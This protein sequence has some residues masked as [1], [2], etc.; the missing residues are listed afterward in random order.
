MGV[1]ENLQGPGKTMAWI[2]AHLDYPH[3]DFCLIWPFA[4]SRNGYAYVS[5]GIAVHRVMCEHR[6][7]P[8]PDDKSQAAHSCGRGHEGCVNPWHLDWKSNAEN[9]IDRYQQNAPAPRN[10]LTP[11]QVDEI[12][13]LEHRERICDTALRFGVSERNI[14]DI[15]SGRIW[16]KDRIDRHQF[17]E[18]EVEF[19][20]SP[21]LRDKTARYFA[22]QFGVS[23]CA[24]QNI[25]SGRSYRHITVHLPQS[26]AQP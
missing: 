10:K 23:I 1:L 14:R 12:R 26:D 7:G 17:T 3:P 24:I 9:Q 16:K 8:A 13:S 19:I 6:N 18:A 11:Q 20:R 2:R 21:S 4:L 22:E 5:G 25:R 15:R